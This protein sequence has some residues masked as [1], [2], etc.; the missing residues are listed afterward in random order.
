MAEND[1]GVYDSTWWDLRQAEHAAAKAG[2]KQWREFVAKC[3]SRLGLPWSRIREE[4][5]RIPVVCR[6]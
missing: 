6:G 1:R 4:F 2:G 5:D 3:E